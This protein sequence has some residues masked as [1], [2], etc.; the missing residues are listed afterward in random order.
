[1]NILLKK[2]LITDT[3]SPYFN[4]VK[5]VFVQDGIIQTIS[6]NINVV[7]DN[8]V[9][10][11][12]IIASPGWIDVFADFADP[13]FEHKET[14][15]T[16]AAAAVAGG[17]AQVFIIPNTQPV[18]STKTGVGY[19]VQQSKAL[20]VNILPIGAVSKNGEGK[21]LA[22][23]YD[24][25]YGGAVAFSDGLQPVQ[26]A[27]ILLK[28][29]Q[30][31]KAFDGVVIQLP[32]D[33]SINAHGLMN[34]GI[35]STQL[36]L[37]GV[38]AIAEELIIQ[39][40]IELLKYTGSKL[41]ITGIS[42]AKSAELIKAAK[43]EGLNITCSVTPYHLYFCDED[44]RSY[45]TNLKVK[46]P[47]RTAADREALRQAVADGSIDCIATH[48]IPQHWDDKTCEFEYAKSGMIGLQTA[49]AIVQTA[50][51]RLTNEQLVKLF[52]TNAA[53][54]FNLPVTTIQEGKNAAITLF[55]RT[56]KTVLTEETNKSKSGNTPFLNKEL[57]GRVA[58]VI[59]KGVVF[60]NK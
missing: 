6:D 22:E 3:V 49:F 27:G 4:T 41:H 34:E 36:G 31:V 33:K 10:E 14:L 53:S 13:G 51:P 52:A 45:D 15:E 39:R 57:S 7:A 58:G 42:T 5:D 32:V 28:A 35:V 18:I 23:M 40:D 19:V 48:H 17:F 44:L 24:M 47:L 2:V 50:L 54:I 59:N 20:P 21:E 56:A 43:K 9:E 8:I 46:P 55:S 29:L 38:P 30:Y 37:P 11:Q 1:M 26:S 60:L 16:G 12:D 25:Y